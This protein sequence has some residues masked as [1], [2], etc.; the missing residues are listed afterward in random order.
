MGIGDVISKL[1][2]K[3]K[4]TDKT[5]SET[6]TKSEKKGNLNS[7]ATE[8]ITNI[9]TENI[10]GSK[11]EDSEDSEEDSE[12]DKLTMNEITSGE[13]NKE[14]S[15]AKILDVLSNVYDPEIPIDIV[16]LGL[17]YGVEIKNDKVQVNM[18]MTS[19]GCPASA[20]ITAE[21]K[22]LIEELEGVSEATIEIVWDPPWD[23][24]RMSEDA[25]QSMGYD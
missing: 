10:T 25:K 20:Q 7:P 19:P 9:K 5:T 22:F 1:L 14:L 24:S 4:K 21:A 16:N 17:V 6:G 2:K 18:S 11:S 3:E 15:E 23:P 13:N 12:S 8:D